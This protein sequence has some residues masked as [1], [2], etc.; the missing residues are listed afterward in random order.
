[1]IRK[2]SQRHLVKKQEIDR[3]LPDISKNVSLELTLAMDNGGNN[4]LLEQD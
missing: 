4:K 3:E 1:M 2:I